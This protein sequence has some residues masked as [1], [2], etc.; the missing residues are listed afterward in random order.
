MRSASH[1]GAFNRNDTV[2]QM[3]RCSFDI[4]VGDIIGTLMIGATVVMLRP[5]GTLDFAYLTT[6]L[7]MKQV[8]RM[9]SVPSLLQRLF[10]FVEE[11]NRQSAMAHLIR[12]VAAGVYSF[13]RIVSLLQ[14]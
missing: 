13:E 2:V 7:G 9:D 5:G 6:V 12:L 10:Q 1:I 3:A 8:T 4:H 11:H 14:W